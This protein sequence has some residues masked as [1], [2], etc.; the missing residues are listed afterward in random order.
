MLQRGSILTS[1]S[2]T[3]R[4]MF[5]KAI[6]A[7]VLTSLV[8][9]NLGAP[10]RSSPPQV[11]IEER[12][13]RL[14]LP[15][16]SDDLGDVQVLSETPYESVGAL[17]RE[18]HTIADPQRAGHDD[19]S[20]TEHLIS[21]IA[22]LRYLTGGSD[23][24]TA[25]GKDFCAKTKW[26]F[27]N[28]DEEKSRR[29]WLYFDRANCVTFFALWPSRYR[30][31]LAPVDAQEEIIRQWNQWYATEGKT[32]RFVSPSESPEKRLL[33]WQCARGVYSPP[34]SAHQ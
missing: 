6:C 25:R 14:G 7:A 18:L 9:A 2:T 29:Y 33:L 32:Y 11:G 34:P 4:L 23:F 19:A 13:H 30:V 1:T 24:Y 8:A 17:V 10:S 20:E 31:Y 5:L 28:S 26:K 22:A 3:T 21:T 15:G 16:D 27:G 12:V